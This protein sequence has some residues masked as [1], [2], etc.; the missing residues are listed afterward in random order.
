M[1]ARDDEFAAQVDI[2]E[3]ED[4]DAND[5]TENVDGQSSNLKIELAPSEIKSFTRIG[6]DEDDEEEDES[7]SAED[8][9][10]TAVSRDAR[11]ENST[12]ATPQATSA[13]E[14]SAAA[15]EVVAKDTEYVAKENEMADDVV[16][17]ADAGSQVIE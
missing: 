6:S 14:E 16:T 13:I 8:P 1:Q 7:V 10:E 11:N 3:Q 15:P 17:N 9:S 4:A 5:N 12:N 2:G